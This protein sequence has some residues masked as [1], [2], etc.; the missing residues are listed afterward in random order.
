MAPS[1][2]YHATIEAIMRETA[3]SFGL[4]DRGGERAKFAKEGAVF[5]F[6]QYEGAEFPASAASDRRGETTAD[7]PRAVGDLVRPN[8]AGS[9]RFYRF[10]LRWR[11]TCSLLAH[12]LARTIS[13]FHGRKCAIVPRQSSQLAFAAG[14][15]FRTTTSLGA[16]AQAA[17]SP[18]CLQPFASFDVKKIARNAD[19]GLRA[20]DP[21]KSG[22]DGLEF[23]QS[24]CGSRC[25]IRR[26]VQPRPLP[27]QG[28]QAAHSFRQISAVYSS[29]CRPS[30]AAVSRL[31][32][33]AEDASSQLQVK[34]SA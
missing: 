14:M 13:Q 34:G 28:I 15:P 19:G 12:P 6:A 33:S 9:R 10:I 2:T 3:L 7:A 18:W 24:F 30:R 21:G 17:A 25:R 31:H 16:K 1:S 8:A 5:T 26:R 32:L 23:G 20:R 27:P 22:T 11:G 4:T 29:P